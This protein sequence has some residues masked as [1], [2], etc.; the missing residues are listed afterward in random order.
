MGYC[1]PMHTTPNEAGTAP[2][3]TIENYKILTRD[4]AGPAAYALFAQLSPADQAAV[5]AIN[6]KTYPNRD[7]SSR[8]D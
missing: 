8:F 2:A 4:G 3:A 7:R 5:R 6:A 1:L